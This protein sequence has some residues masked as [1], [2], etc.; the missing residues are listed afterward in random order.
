VHFG[1]QKGRSP[2]PVLRTKPISTP[3]R[4][5]KFTRHK[6]GGSVAIDHQ[7]L[8]HCGCESRAC[9][10]ENHS[11]P[12]LR[13]AKIFIFSA[14]DR[15]ATGSLSTLASIAMGGEWGQN[16]SKP[17][18]LSFRPGSVMVPPF[19]LCN[20]V[21]RNGVEIAVRSRGP[22]DAF[23]GEMHCLGW[24]MCVL[25]GSA[26]DDRLFDLH[27]PRQYSRQEAKEAKEI[28]A[29]SE[30]RSCG[31]EKL[32]DNP[33]NSVRFLHRTRSPG[34]SPHGPS[35]TIRHSEGV[36]TVSDPLGPT[37][38]NCSEERTTC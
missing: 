7:S 19:V 4:F 15:D 3:F 25:V 26:L 34:R 30:P 18:Q 1:A 9:R 32:L 24:W 10:A 16:L 14:Y 22:W 33:R 23:L 5:T 28:S 35:P 38:D 17:R 20:F 11:L 36:D 12:F 6:E 21:R 2:G 27:N 8:A 13:S 29:K 37:N 31:G